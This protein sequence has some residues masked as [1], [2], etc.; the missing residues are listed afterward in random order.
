MR[1]CAA[2]ILRL[3]NRGP[4]NAEPRN[5]YLDLCPIAI[6][7]DVAGAEAAADNG[8]ING[9]TKYVGTLNDR[10]IEG[11]GV[12]LRGSRGEGFSGHETVVTIA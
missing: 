12:D 6:V 1:E 7:A 10:H 8:H 5:R 11:R 3:K 4:E 9:V 2:T